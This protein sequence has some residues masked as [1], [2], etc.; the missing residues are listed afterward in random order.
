MIMRSPTPAAAL[1]AGLLALAACG[2]VE[3]AEFR[4]A[5]GVDGAHGDLAGAVADLLAQTDAALARPAAE[6]VEALALRHAT[7]SSRNA[8]DTLRIRAVN[9]AAELPDHREENATR[10]IAALEALLAL[11][12]PADE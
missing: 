1:L 10:V 6:R 9:Y 11:E 12:V 3:P 5:P 8:A 7:A 2:T 4:P